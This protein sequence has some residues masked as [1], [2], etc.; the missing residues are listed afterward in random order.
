MGKSIG[1][2]AREIA[3]QLKSFFRESYHSN[4]RISAISLLIALIAATS[5]VDLSPRYIEEITITA[6]GNRPS[7]SASG[8]EVWLERPTVIDLELGGFDVLKSAGWELKNGI[9]I[10]RNHQPAEL[11]IKGMFAREQTVDFLKHAYSGEAEIETNGKKTSVDL[12]QIKRSL[13]AI[14]LTGYFSETD[15]SYLHTFHEYLV[16]VAF[17]CVQFDSSEGAGPRKQCCE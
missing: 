5:S 11:R 2:E 8:S 3:E 17:H 4:R 13:K 14:H 6:T 12:F 15:G 10:S 9:F 7:V 1:V 16:H